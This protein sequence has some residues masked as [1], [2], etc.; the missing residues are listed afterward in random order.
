MAKWSSR[1]FDDIV[2]IIGI[3]TML[4]LFALNYSAI[5]GIC[6]LIMYFSLSNHHITSLLGFIIPIPI[7]TFAVYIEFF[8]GTAKKLCR[9]MF[10]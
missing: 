2:L 5:W 3:I 10:F 7:A 1:G 6:Y 8:N 4:V 9:K